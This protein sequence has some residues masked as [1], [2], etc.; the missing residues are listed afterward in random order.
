MLARHGWEPSAPDTVPSTGWPFG[1]FPT[2]E[3]QSALRSAPASDHGGMTLHL[4]V[5]LSPADLPAAELSAARLDGEL[6][7]V[8]DCYTPIDMP[9]RAVSRAQSLAQDLSARVIVELHSAA[10]VL[11]ATDVAP[12]FPQYCS[13]AG[14]RAK[15]AAIRRLSVREVVIGPDE[16]LCLGGVRV[17]SALR[18]ACDLA[19][20]CSE[21]DTRTQLMVLRLLQL[22]Q[23]SVDDCV[24]LLQGRRNLPGKRRT[25]DRLRS[26]TVPGS[27]V[28]DAVDVVHGVDAPNSVQDTV[29]VGGIPHLEDEFTESQPVRRG[30]DGRREDVHVML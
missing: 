17:T 8:A 15:P 6:F 3:G 20:S 11:G 24:E 26:M 12:V 23:A 29:E 21:F 2:D 30:G 7:A 18:T 27:P 19:R 22:A 9:D 16:I 1:G 5:V 4:P 28:T 10:W 14:A 25:L 13:A